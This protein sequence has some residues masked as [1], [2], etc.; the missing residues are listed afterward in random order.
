MSAQCES[1]GETERIRLQRLVEKAHAD[2]YKKFTAFEDFD[3]DE[4]MS[5]DEIIDLV[6]NGL[7]LS[8]LEAT[9]R[10]QAIDFKKMRER[11]NSL[12]TQVRIQD[13]VTV[14][15]FTAGNNQF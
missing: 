2:R 5:D 12:P 14:K 11:L 4:S 15:N 10:M 1:D 3:I 7:A 13:A 6:A 8:K 9:D